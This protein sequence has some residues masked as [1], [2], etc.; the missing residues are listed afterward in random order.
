MEAEVE[1]FTW[2]DI[3]WGRDP[4]LHEAPI[5]SLNIT[6]KGHCIGSFLTFW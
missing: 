4:I 1:A 6:S 2:S 3:T 5:V